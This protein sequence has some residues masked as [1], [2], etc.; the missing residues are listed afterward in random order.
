VDPTLSRR[1]NYLDRRRGRYRF[2]DTTGLPAAPV[3]Q[4]P[5]RQ[6]DAEIVRDGVCRPR[7]VEARAWLRRHDQGARFERAQTVAAA[8]VRE[9]CGLRARARCL[10]L[11]HRHAQLMQGFRLL[12]AK[13]ISAISKESLLGVKFHGRFAYN[14]CRLSWLTKKV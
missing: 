7:R 5:R 4:F 3:L 10:S 2:R 11:R 6:G 12:R 13:R 14:G 8:P 9:S 1:T